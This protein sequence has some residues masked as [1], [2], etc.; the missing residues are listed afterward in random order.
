MLG[1]ARVHGSDGRDRRH[2]VPE[3]D[4]DTP[5]GLQQMRMQTYISLRGAGQS[6]QIRDTRNAESL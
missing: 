5:Q 3:T 6:S 1:G 2:S 4:R